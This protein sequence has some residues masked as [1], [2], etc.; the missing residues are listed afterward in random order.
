MVFIECQEHDDLMVSITMLMINKRL[1]KPH[2]NDNTSGIPS[3]PCTSPL[4]P[5]IN[6]V[7]ESVLKLELSLVLSLFFLS[8]V[9]RK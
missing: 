5:I 9:E 1:L 8:L 7:Q 6:Q 4:F 3:P 2:S